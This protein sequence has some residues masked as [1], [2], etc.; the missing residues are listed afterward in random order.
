MVEAASALRTI[1]IVRIPFAESASS[2]SESAS[3]PKSRQWLLAHVTAVGSK[4]PSASAV[5]GSARRKVPIVPMGLV[6]EVNWDSRLKKRASDSSRNDRIPSN[7][8]SG[9]LS[10]GHQWNARSPPKRSRA[11]A[12]SLPTRIV[13]PGPVPG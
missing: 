6:H 11:F 8:E 13:N 12:G 4:Y 3:E 10:E 9:S 2:D 1:P 7:T 5:S